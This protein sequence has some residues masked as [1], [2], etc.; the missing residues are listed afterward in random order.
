MSKAIKNILY[1]GPYQQTNYLGQSALRNL[2]EL[3]Q[4]ESVNIIHKN[5]SVDNSD[6]FDTSSIVPKSNIDI[7][8]LSNIDLIIQNLPIEFLSVNFYTT[9]VVIPFINPYINYSN[10]DIFNSFRS[11]LIDDIYLKDHIASKNTTVEIYEQ[12]PPL[13]LNNCEK[14]RYNLGTYDELYKFGFLGDYSEESSIIHKLI[15]TFLTTFRSDDNVCLCLLLTATDQEKSDLESFYTNIKKS[16]RITNY[17]KIIF[18]YNNCGHMDA[19][20]FINNISCYISLNSYTKYCMYEKYCKQTN[21]SYITHKDM[22]C[23]NM[24]IMPVKNNL[25]IELKQN[26]PTTESIARAFIEYM[27]GRNVYRSKTVNKTLSDII[28]KII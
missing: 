5:V 9:N 26:S 12:Q 2:Y 8:S 18:M 14:E 20:R 10:S 21:K 7:G 28:C 4:I 15:Q 25:D 19:I 22:A 3:Q 24:P 16:L 13:I 23:V 27:R 17:D 11:V 1:L 6:I